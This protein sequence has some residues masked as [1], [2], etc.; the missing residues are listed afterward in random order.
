MKWTRSGM[1]VAR[2]QKPRRIGRGTS[3]ATSWVEPRGLEPLTPTL[4]GAISRH[5][6]D[7]QVTDLRSNDPLPRDLPPLPAADRLIWHGSGTVGRNPRPSVSALV[8]TPRARLDVQ[9]RR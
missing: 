7:L 3:V 5:W 2:T 1:F 9:Q 6:I 8:A 4:P